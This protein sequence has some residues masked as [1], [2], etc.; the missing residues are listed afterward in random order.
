MQNQI[1]IEPIPTLLACLNTNVLKN[2]K[3][4]M[5]CIDAQAICCIEELRRNIL[6]H[7]ATFNLPIRVTSGYR[8][9]FCNSQCGG[10]AT[11]QHLYGEAADLWCCDNAA[12]FDYIKGHCI[13]DQLIFEKSSKTNNT[14][15]HVSYTR[16]YSNRY[17]AFTAVS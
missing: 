4:H 15:V 14:W 7:L 11:S 13:F 5:I 16:R 17:M 1:F 10:S 2:G 12:L 8:D 6:V 3:K 9:L